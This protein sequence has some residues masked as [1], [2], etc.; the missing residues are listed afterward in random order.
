MPQDLFNQCTSFYQYT[1]SE[2]GELLSP[3]E[4]AKSV[5]PRMKAPT[6]GARLL[7]QWHYRRNRRDLC[8]HHNLSRR[9]REILARHLTFDRPLIKTVKQSADRTVKFLFEFADGHSVET[10]LIPFAGKYTACLSS[11]VGCAMRCSFCLTGTQGL[12]RNLRTEEIVGQFIE[13]KRWLQENRPDDCRLLNVV[14]MGQGEPLQNFTSVKKA[15]QIFLEPCGLGLSPAKVTVS[16]A[17]YVPGLRRWKHEMPPVNLA[18]SLHAAS[19]EKRNR[20]VPLNRKY[21]LGEIF[22]I[23]DGWPLGKK[24]FVTF[25]M[26][27]IKGCND[28]LAD[29]Q[30]TARLLLGRPAMVNLIPVNGFPGSVYEKPDEATIQRYKDVLASFGV[31]ATIRRAKGD[32][33][34]AACG[35]LKSQ[36]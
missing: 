25:E 18:F 9:S 34:L 4:A 36:E 5:S 32:E 8:N 17:G 1:L 3:A 19:D 27:L 2:L 22:S 11:Q 14:F 31:P 13:A 16:T 15:V 35:Q 12:V 30:A 26:I 29:A 24:R 28:S 33:I 21:P 7:F 10:V 23:L 6:G 20:L